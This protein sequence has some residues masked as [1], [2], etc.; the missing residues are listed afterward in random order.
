MHESSNPAA[1]KNRYWIRFSICCVWL[2][3]AV[4]SHI[5]PL[6][7]LDIQINVRGAIGL[8]AVI[9]ETTS[10]LAMIWLLVL[11]KESWTETIDKPSA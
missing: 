9:I 7:S 1:P 11:F 10:P 8:M 5:I 3:S 4:A 2:A 6:D